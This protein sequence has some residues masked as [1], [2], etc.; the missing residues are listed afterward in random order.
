[1]DLQQNSCACHPKVHGEVMFET[2]DY[3]FN[4]TNATSM[5]LICKE[6]GSI[7]PDKFP[8]DDSLAQAYVNYYTS[9]K[10]S[11]GLRKLFRSLL[12]KLQK[13]TTFRN[14]P[15]KSRTICDYGCGSGDYLHTL[16]RSGYSGKLY[17]TDLIKPELE[18]DLIFHWL[19][20]EVF[21]E[22]NKQFDW[23]T[24]SHVL[25]HVSDP[26]QTITGLVA[27]LTENGSIW[28]ATPNSDSF[29]ID[30][31]K[32]W[33]RDVDFPRHRQIYSSS[34]LREIL[35][36]CGLEAEFQQVDKINSVL[37]FVSCTRNLLDDNNISSYTRLTVL[38]KAM[39]RLIKHL[40]IPGHPLDSEAPELVVI[41]KKSTKV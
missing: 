16:N 12:R 1:M 11:S 21:D 27:C 3:N 4:T 31:F 9:K 38:T 23:I 20:M 17:G 34:G 36:R 15:L 7:Y 41:C 32:G 29:L 30:S 13:T 33:A 19:P 28:I 18:D 10:Q 25:E 5:I 8:T 37:N 39:Y 24:M 2:R 40:A 22:H 6:C 35:Y 14:T 26:E